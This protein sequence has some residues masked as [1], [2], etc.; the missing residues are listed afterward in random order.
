MKQK[1]VDRKFFFPD[2]IH[3]LTEPSSLSVGKVVLLCHYTDAKTKPRDVK[4]L[5]QGQVANR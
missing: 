4:E 2:N 1:S 5:V 3:H